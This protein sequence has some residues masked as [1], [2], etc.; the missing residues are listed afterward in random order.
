MTPTTERKR[1]TKELKLDPVRLVLEQGHTRTDVAKL[2]K[3]NSQMSDRWVKEYQEDNDG[4]TFRCN[5][6]LTPL[7]A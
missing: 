5:G 4:Q 1:Y 3:I 6:S 2:L 7:Q